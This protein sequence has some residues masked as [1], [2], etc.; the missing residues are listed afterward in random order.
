MR[1]TDFDFDLPD[2]RI[3]LRPASPRDSARMLVVRSD[4]PLAD[5][6]VAD[7]P[8]FLRAGSSCVRAGSIQ[9]SIRASSAAPI[10]DCACTGRRRA[11]ISR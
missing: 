7:L 5:H 3:A 8:D 1:L 11:W 9:K 2:D 4:A 10:L 6:V